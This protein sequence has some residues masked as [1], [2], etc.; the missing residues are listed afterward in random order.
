MELKFPVPIPSKAFSIFSIPLLF[1][2][3]IFAMNFWKFFVEIFVHIC[4]LSFL[5]NTRLFVI[6]GV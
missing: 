1:N 3:P 6:N 5:L 4:Q 2:Q